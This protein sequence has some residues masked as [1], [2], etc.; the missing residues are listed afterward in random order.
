ML[1]ISIILSQL[2]LALFCNAL[3]Q[4]NILTFKNLTI[5]DGLS[6]NTINCIHQDRYGFMWVGTQDGLNRYDGYTFIQY[7]NER[8]N[9]NSLSNNY[10]WDIYEDD[11]G[12]LWIATFGGGLNKI[13]PLTGE[14]TC[15]KFNPDDSTSFPSNR[16]FSITESPK[17]ILW[18]G[19][20][21]G[22]IRFNKK[23]LRSKIFFAQKNSDNVYKDNY[24]GIE[25][26]DE[27]GNVW[28]RCDS[29]LT[30]IN[31]KS[32]QVK[33]FRKSPYS[34]SIELGNVTDIKHINDVLLVTCSAGLVEINLK[35]KTDKLLLTPSTIQAGD[36]TPDFLKVLSLSNHHYAIG[37]NMG[38]ILFDKLTDR[39][40]IYQNDPEDV[41]SISHNKVF[42]LFQSNDK[43]IWVGTQNGLNQIESET[44]DFIH[45]RNIR[46][47][48]GL[49]SKDVKCFIEEQDSLLWIGTT[50]GLN[51]YNLR[52][53]IFKV[54]RS[55]G[56]NAH[57]MLSNYI[58]CLFKDSKGNK[59]MG[60]KG[61]GFY[62]IE[63]N[64]NSE[65]KITRVTPFN[66]ATL[67]VSVHYIT[68]DNACFLWIGTGGAGLWKYSPVDNTIKKY[69]T[70][71][72]G[73]GPSHPYVYTILHDSY[74]N[75][76]IGTPTGGLNLFNPQSEK[77]IY[78]QNKQENANSISNNIILSLHEDKQSNLWIG[79]AGGL[80]K[81]IPKLGKN[82]FQKLSSVH[83][84]SLFQSYSEHQGFP[85]DV[86]YGILEDEHG[87]LWTTTNRGIAVFDMNEA[88]VIRTFDVSDGLQS[89]EFNQNGFFKKKD[90]LFFFGGINGF[91]ICHPDSIKGSQFI[92]PVVLT[93]LSLFNEPVKVG[94]DL[95]KKFFLEKEL[96][97]IDEILLSWQQDVITFEFAALS[98]I[99]PDKN[100][101]SYMLEGFNKDWVQ[102][103]NIR[104]A[105]YTNLDPGNYIFKV[106]ASNSS[107]VW[108]EAGTALK[109]YISTPPW[110]SWYA[111]L[112]YFAL[113][114]CVIYLFIRLRIN[115]VTRE[116]NIQTQIEKAK[117]HEREEFRKKS[118]AD[119]HDEAGN[120]I[121]KITLFTEMA[122]SGID[123][124]EQLDYYL[125]KI[126]LNISELSS[127]MRDFLWV[128]DPQR[129][130][131]FETIT[132]LKD[133]GDSTFADTNILF[134]VCSI[135]IEFHK[136]ILPM[137]VRR[138]ILQIF[139]EA[140]NNCAKHSLAKEVI[141]AA[142]LKSGI[143]EISLSDNGR[144]FD[145][146]EEKNKDK[147]G[148]TIMHDR[149]KNIK[150]AFEI[151]S[152]KD[153]GTTILLKYIIPQMGNGS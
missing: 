152:Q 90:G 127:G 106:R 117:F 15:F 88:Y 111:Y 86:I 4:Q 61:G 8:D 98:Y 109:I 20:N 81:L 1:R 28:F 95:L 126:Q 78:F 101:Y 129:D 49:S 64:R 53:G 31:T 118:A 35:L 85:N 50:D 27:T 17:G 48:N 69:F 13:N 102:A 130:T 91:N 75:L 55:N 21:E 18:I 11:E 139:K 33:Y 22:L 25:T 114:A 6:Q 47:K 97:S 60:T 7:R 52:S 143:I 76:W 128:M 77:F 3:A 119:F 105:T 59:W 99:S 10:I 34:N 46:G 45:I 103:G 115:K 107:G 120:K 122:R 151:H 93:R 23:T 62:K 150:A 112:F 2:F 84:D 137:N 12:I 125:K 87:K 30:M 96:H 113:I 147:Y 104:S 138:T 66:D 121:T 44:P 14:I 92:P 40:S 32:L 56:K 51:L 41:Q 89:N 132:R 116:I 94:S 82:I 26:G 142:N 67:G 149:A 83:S 9:V 54:F 5:E 141:L 24:V 65:I 108:N 16:L 146:N 100:Q 39:I 43:V 80:N 144:G 110:L 42:S 36:R 79:T 145:I 19:G 133:F 72:D 63:N 136:I 73:T 131:L 148:L 74:G 71:K 124:K 37:T 135:I 29:G 38:L 57:P 68:E 140:M 70:A 153:K 58:L 134:S 123:N